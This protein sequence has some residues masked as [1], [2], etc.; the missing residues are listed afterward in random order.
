[1]SPEQRLVIFSPDGLCLVG[2]GEQLA[3]LSSEPKFPIAPR[4]FS[5]AKL[6]V[7][8]NMSS[9]MPIDHRVVPWDPANEDILTASVIEEGKK[10][11]F[12]D[13][14]QDFV[15]RPGHI[16]SV[17]AEK[18]QIL[19]S[20]SKLLPGSCKNFDSAA[21]KSSVVQMIAEKSVNCSLISLPR[22]AKENL[23]LCG[24]LEGKIP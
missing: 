12:R 22:I 4:P 3:L 14:Q 5:I 23:P 15:V 18:R 11:A 17:L 7:V 9:R 16:V 1:M 2:G 24:P 10:P 19:R 8:L 21:C 6:T 20:E 13:V